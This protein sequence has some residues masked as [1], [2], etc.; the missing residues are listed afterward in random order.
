MMAIKVL[1]A[2]ILRKYILKKDNIKP[3]KDIRLKLDILLR[4]VDPITLRIEKR[5]IK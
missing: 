3:V 4:P 2:T 5:T 1:L